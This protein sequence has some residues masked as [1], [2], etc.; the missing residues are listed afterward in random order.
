MIEGKD[1]GFERRA[2]GRVRLSLA[3]T[4]AYYSRLIEVRVEDAIV[5]YD[6]A[7]AVYGSYARAEQNEVNYFE[8]TDDH[9]I[10]LFAP[11]TDPEAVLATLSVLALR[12]IFEDLHP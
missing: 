5:E 10:Y 1:L 2:P 4:H 8:E 3:V 6:A 7:G 12:D 9:H 11:G